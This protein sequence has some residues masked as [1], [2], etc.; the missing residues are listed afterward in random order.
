MNG[1]IK[2]ESAV[3][4]SAAAI[5]EELQFVPVNVSAIDLGKIPDLKQ[6]FRIDEAAKFFGVSN[7]QIRNWIDNGE[8]QTWQVS[9]PMRPHE[10]T[11][12]RVTRESM[13]KLWNDATRRRNG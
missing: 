2:K 9:N 8:L 3:R 4:P 11:H 7:S 5:Q 1:T 10:R 6:G 12:V 13:V